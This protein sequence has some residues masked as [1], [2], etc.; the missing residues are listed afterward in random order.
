M[1]RLRVLL[2]LDCL[3]A[4]ARYVTA[5]AIAGPIVELDL[6]D[7]DQR[8]LRAAQETFLARS[9]V[10]C[11]HCLA[12]GISAHRLLQRLQLP[13]IDGAALAHYQVRTQPY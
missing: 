12:C 3:C 4:G 8:E 13:T 6:R 7:L 11:G 2:L 5:G 10:N 1:K 9:H